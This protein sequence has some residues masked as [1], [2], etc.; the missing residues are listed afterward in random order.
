MRS[1]ILS[2]I[3]GGKPCS[4]KSTKIRVGKNTLSDLSKDLRGGIC[5][6]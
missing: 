3:F 6:W 2:A 1:D 5:V 4:K